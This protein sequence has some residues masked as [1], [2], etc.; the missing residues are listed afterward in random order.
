MQFG[1]FSPNTVLPYIALEMLSF[2]TWG[3]EGEGLE[4]ARIILPAY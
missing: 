2:K 1:F 3:R 4:V